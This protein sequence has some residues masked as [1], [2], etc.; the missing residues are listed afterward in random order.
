MGIGLAI[1]FGFLAAAIIAITAIV[2]VIFS[3]ARKA[4]GK[5]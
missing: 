5:R 3:F 1:A 4:R 2:F